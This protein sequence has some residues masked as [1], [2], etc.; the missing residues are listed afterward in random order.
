MSV[1]SSTMSVLVGASA[2]T[3]TGKSA[4]YE[5]R[6]TGSASIAMTYRPESLRPSVSVPKHSGKR[7]SDQPLQD[8]ESQDGDSAFRPAAVPGLRPRAF[9]SIV[10]SH[11][12]Y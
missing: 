8:L 11:R 7:I 12:T 10:S 1:P 4:E 2:L 9:L 5:V 3:Q 6:T